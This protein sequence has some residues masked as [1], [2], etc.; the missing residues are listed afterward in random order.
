[1]ARFSAQV[2]PKLVF[3]ALAACSRAPAPAPALTATAAAPHDNLS[4][5]VER[6]WDEHAPPGVS[7]APQYLAD[8]LALERRFLA[9]LS[10]VPR[11][12]LDADAG[13]TY[14]IFKRQ[15]ESSIAAFTYPS[16]L[17]P[18]N[19]F[20]SMP[21]QFARAAAA[22]GYANWQLRIDDYQR[23]TKQAIA[24][25]REGV[26]RGYTAPRVLMERL[27]PVLQ[28]LGADASGNVFYVALR[29]M[30]GAVAEPDRTRLTGAVRDTLLPAYRELHDFVRDEYLPRARASVDW[31]ALPLGPAWYAMLVN[32]A[33]GTRLA[34]NEIH[35]IG[36]AEVE[37]IRARLLAL[38]ASALAASASP[39][40]GNLVSA[41]QEL[42]LQTLA[43]MPNVFSSLPP[44]DFEIQALGPSSEAATLLTYRV[45]APQGRAPAI[46]YVNMAP[47]AG[48][49]AA[50]QTASF[51]SEAI[52]GRHYQSALQL[53]RTDLPKFRRFG[54]EP[55]FVDGWALYAAS[56]GEEM[57]LYRDD[58]ARRGALLGQLKCAAALVV[59]TGLHAQ[60]WTRTQASAYLREQLALD[61]ADANSM[62]DRFL[63]LPGDA[64]ACKMGELKFQSLLAQARQQLG[65]RFDI[66]E[67]HA[68]VLKNG[69]MPLD[70]LEAKM[71]LWM[72]AHR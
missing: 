49:P 33:T 34:P 42:K 17:L 37:R 2:L 70:M 61:D 39:A 5:I 53:E 18:V 48:R 16:E 46:L 47:P 26:R 50:L 44:T 38:P 51:L 68:E 21:Q 30:P 69:A 27:L 6:Y 8:S 1:M 31:G 25:M 4:R 36:I 57:G 71:K 41:Y 58:E 56:L 9:E 22:G 43:A 52:P 54:T 66:R 19:P 64:L 12:R 15:R 24:N 72:E 32:R 3:L 55:A 10:T 7:I 35:G 63:A 40:A 62:T 59:D 28:S 67:F 29:T 13:L 20:D 65:S 45:A 60:G 14:D 23:W 11:A